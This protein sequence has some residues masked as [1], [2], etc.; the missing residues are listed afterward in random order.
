MPTTR[1]SGG[2][3][4]KR[5]TKN[6]PSASTSARRSGRC[7]DASELGRLG[8]ISL[9]VLLRAPLLS[10]AF[11]HWLAPETAGAHKCNDI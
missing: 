5:P 3:S 6:V 10:Y 9:A 1:L 11:A 8:G 4:T 2:R 7:S